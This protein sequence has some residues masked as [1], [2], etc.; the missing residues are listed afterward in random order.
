MI[1]PAPGLVLTCEHAGNCVPPAYRHVFPSHRALL[2][3]HRGWD[4]GIYP[5][6]LAVSR[7]LRV[8]LKAHFVTRL[9]VETNRSLTH[10][11]LFSKITRSLPADEKQRVLER[12][13]HPHRARVVAL[14]QRVIDAGHPAL[15]LGFHSFTPVWNGAVRTVDIGLLYDPARPG[16]RS[17]CFVLKRLLERTHPEWRIRMNRPYR[18]T[19][20]GLTTALRK[21]W[22]DRSYRGI[23]IE[24]NQALLGRARDRTR[25]ARSLAQ[26]LIAA[27]TEGENQ[28]AL[29]RGKR[30]Y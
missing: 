11:D 9:L 12:Y 26:C 24:I 16:E 20:D 4:P 23:E 8:P 10:P 18:G 2:T 7:A 30:H 6:A 3:S 17:Y 21:R 14:L 28:A 15:H 22:P 27:S 1:R 19:S 25:I 13:Y 29:P 5:V